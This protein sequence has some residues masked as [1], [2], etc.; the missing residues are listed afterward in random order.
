MKRALELFQLDLIAALEAVEGQFVTPRIA[1]ELAMASLVTF[2]HCAT[3]LTA[4]FLIWACIDASVRRRAASS[5]RIQRNM[6]A[7]LEQAASK[8]AQA[9]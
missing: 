3:L 1:L 2:V 7:K 9:A 5:R 4:A 6:T 8:A